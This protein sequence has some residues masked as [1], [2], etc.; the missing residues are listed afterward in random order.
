MV[1]DECPTIGND[2]SHRSHEV[3]GRF[4]D[5]EDDIVSSR[6]DTLSPLDVVRDSQRL[7]CAPSGITVESDGETDVDAEC[8]IDSGPNGT[9]LVDIGNGLLTLTEGVT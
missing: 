4:D 2:D 5:V 8:L 1:K 3:T 6:S 9:A 7:D